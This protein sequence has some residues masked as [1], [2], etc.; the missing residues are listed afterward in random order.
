MDQCISASTCVHTIAHNC[1]ANTE[2][3]KHMLIYLSNYA[4]QTGIELSI[5]F[6]LIFPPWTHF[7]QSLKENMERKKKVARVNQRLLRNWPRTGSCDF[8]NFL[9]EIT[10]GIH[11]CKTNFAEFN[12]PIHSLAF[13]AI[14]LEQLI[15]FLVSEALASAGHNDI[16][17][18][19]VIQLC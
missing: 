3:L 10:K 5:T 13:L 1:A 14:H 12:C 4:L 18:K 2:L 9:C 11:S 16:R 6:L 7:K 17:A 8:C 19:I 15:C